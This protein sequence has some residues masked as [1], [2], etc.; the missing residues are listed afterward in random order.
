MGECVPPLK[1]PTSASSSR[2]SQ[3]KLHLGAPSHERRVR[4]SAPLSKELQEQY[5]V[6]SMPIRK[7]DEVLV[8]RGSNNGREGKVVASYRK[9][10]VIHIERLNRE[11]VSGQTRPIGI[12]PSNV[13]TTKLKID[14]DRKEILA[15]KDRSGKRTA[16]EVDA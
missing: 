11:K 13:V 12:H 6:R 4:M 2:R 8:K 9:R 16:M 5:N 1:M 15:R 10:Y 3:R 14:K 7:D